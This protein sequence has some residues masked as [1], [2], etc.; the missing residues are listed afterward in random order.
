[1]PG[2][3][4]LSIFVAAVAFGQVTP[5]SVTV[6][7][8]RNGNVQP[9][10]I[11]FGIAVNSGLD[12]TRDDIVA[13]LQGSGITL[14]NFSSVN[15]IQLSSAGQASTALVWSFG[16][17]APLANMKST[18]A[19]LTALQQSL[20]QKKG[21]PTL[22][23]SVQGTQVS[24]QLQQSQACAQSDLIS[25]ARAL[26][27]KMASA[28]G[29]SLGSILAMSTSTSTTAPGTDLLGLN[30]YNFSGSPGCSLTVKF[31]LGGF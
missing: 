25:D 19:S 29:V 17:A 30:R 22:A 12:A 2:R 24:Q 15:T 6:T 28:A 5:N 27:Q 31:A 1:M 23:F 3:V 21:G 26:A 18:I 10:Q 13:A 14:A 7:A 20:A 11:V 9:D 4:F 16:L 8:S